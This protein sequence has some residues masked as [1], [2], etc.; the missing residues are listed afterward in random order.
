[1]SV[2]TGEYYCSK[3]SFY[4]RVWRLCAWPSARI[5]S[6]PARGLEWQ[7]RAGVSREVN[8]L[9]LAAP[10]LIP[11]QSWPQSQAHAAQ[12]DILSLCIRVENTPQKNAPYLVENPS[13]SR[14][15][16]HFRIV[17][18]PNLAHNINLPW[19]FFSSFVVQ[20]SH[21]HIALQYIEKYTLEYIRTY[22]LTLCWV[23]STD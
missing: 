2:W 18:P 12:S 19:G 9:A 5:S 1:M 4:R 7:M 11:P 13:N 6:P 8:I 21:I 16:G 15:V 17:D 3:Q 23:S 20:T 10:V 22:V 14:V